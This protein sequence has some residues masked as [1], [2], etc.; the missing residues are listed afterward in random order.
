MSYTKRQLEELFG[1]S[2][3]GVH[4]RLRDCGLDS[5]KSEYTDEEINN[6]FTVACDMMQQGASRRDVKEHFGV[7]E[8]NQNHRQQD[9]NQNPM[10]SGTNNSSHVFTEGVKGISYKFFEQEVKQAVERILPYTPLIVH[11]EWQNLINSGAVTQAFIDYRNNV[12]TPAWEQH[13]EAQTEDEI[14]DPYSM[15]GLGA[16]PDSTS[17]SE[18]SMED[19]IQVD[20]EIPEDI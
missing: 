8:N 3:S 12:Q 2:K 13:Y 9:T 6:H 15:G 18:Y 16:A 17:D 10:G 11:Q 14:T 20:D 7:S 19:D 5:S 4:N 1:L